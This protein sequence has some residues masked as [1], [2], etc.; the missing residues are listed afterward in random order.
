M[1]PPWV[2]QVLRR[3]L[4]LI[5]LAVL[6]TGCS[7]VGTSRSVSADEAGLPPPTR[8]VL[9]NG[10]RLII[11]DHRAADVVALYLFVAV[12][13]RDEGPTELGFAHFMEHMLFKGTDTRG[14]GFVDRAIE[15][16]G[17]KTNA[18]TSLDYTFYA[19]VVPTAEASNGIQIL[20]DMAFRSKFDPVELGRE[21]EVILEEARLERDTP[22]TALIR[23]LYGLVFR[24]NAYSQSLL[25]TT[26]TLKAATQET[27]L[28]YYR[29]HYVP[30]KMTLVVAGPVAP[31]TVKAAVQQTFGRIPA[32]GS[33]RPAVPPPGPLTGGIRRAVERP[34]QQAYVALG[35]LA[36]RSDDP[37]GFAV[38]LLATIVGGRESSRLAQTLRDRDQ[39]V[40]SITMTYASLQG[41]GIVSI[42]AE[43]EAGD[44]D[45]V[46]RRIL[47]EIARIQE[48]G[49]TE[50]ERQLALIFFEAEHAFDTETAEGLANAYGVAETTWTL[51][52]ELTYVERLRQVTREQVRDAARR[53]LSRTDYA[54]LVFVP[55]RRERR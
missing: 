11:Q 16:V 33:R 54:R 26:E 37:D 25:G 21:G 48:G 10:M 14:P 34:E 9:P 15:G 40:S 8:Q 41:A 19:L 46:E 43:C 51:E 49:I 28:A 12:G 39:L 36:P 44:V 53:Y 32:A 4:C 52:A 50:D 20:A 47:E 45:K 42:R 3:H 7:A 13:A 1:R 38:D 55:E 35:W 22:R 29:Q 27:L 2:R 6:L 18:N 23:G 31:E 17:G 5:L 24:G 30:D